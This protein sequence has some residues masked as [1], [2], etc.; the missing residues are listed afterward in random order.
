MTTRARSL[1][2]LIAGYFV[3]LPGLACAEAPSYSHQIRPFLARYCVECHNVEKLKGGLN[4]ESFASLMLGGDSGPVVVAG[5]ADQS[6]LILQVEG[7]AKPAMPP[8]KAP[9]PKPDEVRLLRAWVAAGAMNDSSRDTRTLPAI[10]PRVA[11][12]APITS[13]AYRPEGKEI[14]AG[15]YKEVI[16]IDVANGEVVGKLPNQI[17]RV[18]ALAFSRDGHFLAVGASIP[19]AAGEVRIYEETTA[20]AMPVERPLHTLAAHKDAVHDLAWSPDSKLLA[21][22]GYDRLIKLW[23]VATGKEVRVLKD[24]SD[25]VYALAFNP[26]GRLLAS[27]GADRAVK[28]W[29]VDSGRRLYTLIQST[30]WVYAVAW[31]PDGRHL[32]AG[33]VDKSI[34][35]W[36]VSAASARLVRSVVAHEAPIMRLAYAADGES[37]FSVGEDRAA[38]VWDTGH[39]AEQKVYPKQSDNIL[40]FGVRP[41]QKQIAVGLYDGRLLLLDVLSGQLQFEALPEKSKPPKL[42]GISPSAG[43]RGRTIRLTFHGE[44]LERITAVIVSHPAA[45]AKLFAEPHDAKH[46]QAD[47]SFPADAAA[48]VYQLSLKGANGQSGSLPFTLDFFDAVAEK[49]PN[50]SPSAAQRVRLPATL[51]GI[52]DRPGDVDF[53]AFEGKAGQQIGVQAVAAAI[54]STL[55]PVLELTDASGNVL[56]QSTRGTLGYVCQR[57][58]SYAVSIRDREYRGGKAMS[59]RLQVGDVPVATGV[60]PLGLQRGTTAH[61]HIDGVNLGAAS[62]VKIEAPASARPGDMLPVTVRTPQGSPFGDLKVVVGQFPEVVRPE[63]SAAGSQ[64]MLL[65]V[66]GTANGRIRSKGA[67]EVWRFHAKK[68][69]ALIIETHARRL[70]SPLDSSI[71]VLDRDGR[72]VPRAVLRCLAKTYVTFRDHDSTGAGIRVEDW[73]DLAINDY[74]FV[75]DELVRIKALPKNPDDDCQFFA[76]RDQRIGYLDTT[77][78][79]HSMG[80]PMYKVSI[81]PPG[82]TFPPNG[83]PLLTL[84]YRNDDGGPGYGKD[85]RLFFDPPADGEFLVRIADARGLGG[86]DYAYRL[87]VRPPQPDFRVRVSPTSP[88]VW[89]GGAVPLSVSADRIDGFDE[90]IHIQLENLPRGF[91]APP[92]SIPAEETSTA[93]ALAVDATASEPAK[94]RPFKVVARAQIGGKEQVRESDAGVPKIVDPGEIGVTTEQKE[95]T[96]VPGGQ[97]A[98]LA[99]IE[100]RNGFKGRVPLEVRGLPHGVRVLDIGLNGIL[101]TEQQNA[102]QFV[103][104]AEPWVHATTHPFVVVARH[105]VKQTDFA[106]PSVLLRVGSK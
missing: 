92:T 87:T 98:V 93:F 30:D 1:A 88:A 86:N 62:S 12:A 43:P 54:G 37:L 74:I 66:P 17:G 6:P 24:H 5:N 14:A 9:Q 73:A 11:T 55:E 81:H 32:A 18:T 67:A 49:E 79:F 101:I 89:R 83:L 99:R 65:H 80:T 7:K 96:V 21:T 102:R 69:A 104:Y 19:A 28:V 71:E 3:I 27:G 77:P 51:V 38:K 105:E 68:G 60:F 41:D 95:V 94:G 25:A 91:H 35:I 8:K 31:S 45:K 72:P 36:E 22:C 75:G 57:A 29:D 47:L 97:V 90:P 40:A 84:C 26:D 70:G 15:S 46:I 10:V 58:G 56:A 50:D 20:G 85:S 44:Y 4:V 103:I 16:F 13:L 82:T 53:Y 78:T 64:P 106:A 52:I 76:V 63:Q 100:R 33:G 34:R 39:M 48:G 42:T 23:D 59:Y 2:S 61:I